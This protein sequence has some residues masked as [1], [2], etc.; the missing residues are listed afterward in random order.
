M[1]AERRLLFE[2]YVKAKS[3]LLDYVGKRKD[4]LA[5]WQY[6][7]VS[8]PGVSDLD[9]IAVIKEKCDPGIADYLKKENF[10]PLLRNVMAHANL[11][12][13]PETTARDMLYWDDMKI[14][15]AKNG[16]SIDDPKDLNFNFRRMA[17]LVDWLFERAYRIFF[18]RKNGIPNQQLGLGL[19]KSFGYCVDNYQV[20]NPDADLTVYG[21]LKERITELRNQWLEMGD[22]ERG[23]QISELI[24][25]FYN[26]VVQ[27]HREVYEYLNESEF[28]PDWNQT[29]KEYKFTF[30]DGLQYSFEDNYS[31]RDDGVIIL[32]KKLLNHFS[33]YTSS[34][35]TLSKALQKS[36]NEP[37]PLPSS[38]IFYGEYRDFLKKRIDIASHWYDCLKS[39]GF[40]YGLLKFGWYIKK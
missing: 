8:Q 23:K 39:N 31:R 15:G 37:P 4:I 32:P 2:D 26:F 17:M 36:F 24:D 25:D 3:I 35:S 5:I 33:I 19:M 6:G 14:F 12:I 30:P 29:A 9:L 21:G 28:Y 7:E 20:V 27:C 13:V 11:I 40:T 16:E 38:K 1:G 10:D 34:K 18:I 22:P